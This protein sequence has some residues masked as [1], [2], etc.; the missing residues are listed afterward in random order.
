MKSDWY[1]CI[2]YNKKFNKFDIVCTGP[3]NTA[4]EADNNTKNINQTTYESSRLIPVC[5]YVPLFMKEFI[6][7]NKMLYEI[8]NNEHF[9]FREPI[10]FK[11]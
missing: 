1:T 4:M 9:R 11:K 2:R 5:S 3:F 6:V 7:K 10:F 8:I